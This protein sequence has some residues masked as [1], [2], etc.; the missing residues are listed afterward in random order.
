M[1]H[2]R[3]ATAYNGSYQNKLPYAFDDDIESVPLSACPIDLSLRVKYSKPLHVLDTGDAGYLAIDPFYQSMIVELV[4]WIN[5][6]SHIGILDMLATL[7][8]YTPSDPWPL[9]PPGYFYPY[10]DLEY[11]ANEFFWNQPIGRTYD[12][13]GGTTFGFTQSAKYECLTGNWRLITILSMHNGAW[14]IPSWG[15][16]LECTVHAPN[17]MVWTVHPF[18]AGSYLTGISTSNILTMF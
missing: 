4:N 3:N 18:S 7:P 1:L 10:D 12:Y 17:A 9:A 2:R 13:G 5:A 11:T 15:F 6:Q 16:F 8:G 14:G